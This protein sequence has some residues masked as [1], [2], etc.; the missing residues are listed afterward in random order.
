MLSKGS[1]STGLMRGHG[2]DGPL[3]GILGGDPLLS[4]GAGHVVTKLLGWHERN[5]GLDLRG[6]GEGG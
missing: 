3:E 1:R 2:P 4:G 6:F 5:R